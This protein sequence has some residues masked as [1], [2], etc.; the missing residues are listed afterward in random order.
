MTPE[1]S[2]VPVSVLNTESTLVEIKLIVTYFW[3]VFGFLP[4]VASFGGWS[5]VQALF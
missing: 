1:A 2:K 5:M 3:V 4:K